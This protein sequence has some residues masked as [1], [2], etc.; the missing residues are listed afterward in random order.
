[1]D[2]SVLDDQ[3]VSFLK[4]NGWNQERYFNPTIWIDMLINEGYKCNA[5]AVRILESFGGLEFS[6]DREKNYKHSSWEFDFN[7][8]DAGSGE[9]DRIEVFE[10]S[11]NE[12]LFPLGMIYQ[13]FLY[14]GESGVIYV[15]SYDE[16][17]AIAK[18]IEEFFRNASLEK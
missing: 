8:Y 14:V 2:V 12:S 1:M 16:I 10:K 5:H 3:I 7:A 17:R 6:K 13:D 4:K 18:N 11:V 15:G 9:F